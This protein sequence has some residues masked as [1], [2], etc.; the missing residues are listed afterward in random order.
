M[1][2]RSIVDRQNEVETALVKYAPLVILAYKDKGITGFLFATRTQRNTAPWFPTDKSVSPKLAGSLM[3]FDN[4]PHQQRRG[5]VV[6]GIGNYFHVYS[7][8]Q[9]FKEFLDD[10]VGENEAHPK[11]H[12][13]VINK[14]ADYIDEEYRTSAR[15]HG[16]LVELA[17]LSYLNKGHVNVVRI[18]HDGDYHEAMPFCILGGLQTMKG[19]DGTAVTI[20]HQALELANALYPKGESDLPD[21]KTAGSLIGKILSLGNYPGKIIFGQVDFEGRKGKK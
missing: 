1:S 5:A 11:L 19:A 18:K 13:M 16:F 3:P 17:V 10:E 2:V 20:R 15:R 8:A 6:F 12:E 9:I 4:E 7:L 14:F 21:I